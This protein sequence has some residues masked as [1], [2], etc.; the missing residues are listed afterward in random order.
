MPE[1]IHIKNMVCNRCIKVVQDEFEK[2][3]L[4]VLNIKLG[5]VTVTNK[6]KVDKAVIKKVLEENGFE[7]LDSRKASMIEKIKNTIIKTIQRKEGIDTDLNFSQ[8][9]QN[10]VGN[11]YHYLSTLFS[12]TEGITIER[13]IILQRIEKAK[14]LLVYDELTLSQIAYRLGYSSVAHLS[15]Q[16]KK[17][18]GFTPSDFKKSHQ[19]RKPLDKVGK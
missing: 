18:T 1:T 5:E 2:L 19:H 16:F 14:E 12:S 9:L 13:Y 15:A 17:V 10:E 7:L 6:K 4:E 11:E 8:L 3:G